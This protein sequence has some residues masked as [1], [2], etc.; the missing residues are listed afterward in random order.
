MKV[1]PDRSKLAWKRRVREDRLCRFADIW[2]EL[3]EAKMSEINATLLKRIAE[4]ETHLPPGVNLAEFFRHNADSISEAAERRFSDQDD[5][6]DKG[7]LVADL[8]RAITRKAQEPITADDYIVVVKRLVQY[9]VHGKA[10]KDWFNANVQQ[11]FEKAKD[12]V[13]FTSKHAVPN[14]QNV[15]LK[16]ANPDYDPK[17]LKIEEVESPFDK[18]EWDV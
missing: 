10:L 4:G 13:T 14:E 6:D 18:E 1:N 17:G 8:S 12:T 5:I 7:K 11:I 3:M 2:A 15:T 9:W 16:D